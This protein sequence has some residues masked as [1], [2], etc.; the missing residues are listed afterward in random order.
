MLRRRKSGPRQLRRAAGWAVVVAAL[1]LSL[2][3]LHQYRGWD[4]SFYLAQTSSLIE[5]GDLDLRNDFMHV[6]AQPATVLN[7]LTTIRVNGTLKNTFA[8]GPSVL[9]L[10]AYGVGMPLRPAPAAGG[11]PARWARPQLVAL[12]LL[13]VA[14]G[15]WLLWALDRWLRRMGVARWL[16]ALG[17][18]ALVMG[19]PLLIYGFRQYTASHL[20]STLAVLWMVLAA[21]A[22]GRR[23]S[24][25]AALVCG[26]ALGMAF[27][28]RWQD[29][30]KGVVLLVPAW[31]LARR[32]YPWRQGLKLAAAAAGGALVM[33]A[34]QL[35]GWFL[36]R[37]EIFSLPQGGHYLRWSEPRLENFLFSGLS[38]L[39]PWSPVF[40]L[41]IAGLLLPWRNRLPVSWRWVALAVL[42]FDIYVNSTVDDWWGG[43]AYGAR[44]MCSDVPLLAL[45]L[46]NLCRWRVSRKAVAAALV[47]CCAWGA[48]T[49]NL[50][51]LGLRDLN[52]LVR[53]EPS[54]APGAEREA[55]AQPSPGEARAGFAS[56]PLP[57]RGINYFPAA[58][59][60]PLRR[61]ATAAV[62]LAAALAAAWLLARARP[63][64][65]LR[66]TLLALLG[67]V[68]FGHLRLL[69]GAP[70]DAEDR[71]RWHQMCLR[72]TGAAL[73]IGDF[74][75]TMNE[76]LAA[77]ADGRQD[78]Y[79]LVWTFTLRRHG[80]AAEARAVAAELADRGYPS[81]RR[82]QRVA[83][84]DPG[85]RL[86]I[87]QPRLRF[88]VRPERPF[89]SAV[90]AR[91]V[92]L[93][94]EA[95]RLEVEVEAGLVTPNA[96]R[97]LVA[98]GRRGWP[99]LLEVVAADRD[100]LVLRTATG[101]AET[102]L[103][104]RTGQ[105]Y[106][107]AAEWWPPAGQ[108]RLTVIAVGG[109]PVRLAAS[110]TPGPQR[111]GRVEVV[112]GA[113]ADGDRYEPP[114][115][116]RFSGLKLTSRPAAE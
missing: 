47:A 36:E 104:W 61:A 38:S 60:R 8:I 114:W 59:G 103:A 43:A 105:R 62:V 74:D 55:S 110:A 54:H 25:L 10:P 115:Q 89:R 99:P 83:A 21:V 63:P 6:V 86:L 58:R 9:W 53:G 109:E 71:R 5:D 27:L 50:Y 19:T 87:S 20:A 98:L 73:R 96:E 34:L 24:P 16:A 42:A 68:L 64:T 14:L 28:C 91:Q 116:A 44:R 65:L 41:G 23:P 112:L 75:R 11:A 1:S 13:T 33:A 26:L 88:R 29:V 39:V 49:S 45:G 52:I 82:L 31:E 108:A 7:L 84:L 37:G 70:A 40:A 78:A 69:A 72:T 57:Y 76:L 12:H 67:G 79:R 80:R 102:V 101:S 81:S 32:R 2:G 95:L 4:Q 51:V 93:E 90:F 35:H 100:R 56:W 66:V 107:L 106:R 46:G 94:R 15:V 17:A 97:R 18:L 77:P 22:L 113:A 85:E 48:V 111:E 30:V 92:D 3:W